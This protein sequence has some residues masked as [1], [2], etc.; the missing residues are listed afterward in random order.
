MKPERELTSEVVDV[1]TA[2]AVDQL[3]YTSPAMRRR[4]AEKEAVLIALEYRATRL[5]PQLDRE[6]RAEIAAAGIASDD[7]IA[8]WVDLCRIVDPDLFWLDDAD[9]EGIVA[10]IHL[11]ARQPLWMP[12]PTYE[13]LLA[14]I[15]AQ[16]QGVGI[17]GLDACRVVHQHR[18][19]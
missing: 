13:S 15:E 2:I 9:A 5:D 4:R 3:L 10:A 6:F 18:R 17:T 14:T 19:C 16:W 11:L 7:L 8:A 1:A 12:A